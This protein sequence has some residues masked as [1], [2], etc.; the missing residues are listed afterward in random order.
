MTADALS[1]DGI[2]EKYAAKPVEDVP[3]YHHKL[4]IT[5]A[6]LTPDDRVLDIGCGTGSLALE[7]A[8]HV[9]QVHAVDVSG[10]MVRIGQQK[11]SALNVSNVAFHRSA[12]DEPLPFEAGSFD[13]ICAFSI[14]HL[15]EDRR[16]ALERIHDL[17]EPGGSFIS[18]TVCLRASMVPYGPILRVMRWFG[19]AP[20]VYLIDE[21]TLARD[22]HDAGFVDISSP[23]VGAKKVVAFMVANKPA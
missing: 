17:L 1:W 14:L 16:G 11:A 18:S 21:A 5:K 13:V 2:A 15:L 9:A 6:R 22:F 3:A 8:P 4:E 7:L 10:E 19:K 23:E 20:P 12:F